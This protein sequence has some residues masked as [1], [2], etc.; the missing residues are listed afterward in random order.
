MLI[1]F[2]TK[3]IVHVFLCWE[4]VADKFDDSKRTFNSNQ[5]LA[6]WQQIAINI[7]IYILSRVNVLLTI[8]SNVGILLAHT[9]KDRNY[10]RTLN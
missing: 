5:K 3:I 6:N 7:L 10:T 8:I 2:Q 9:I 1:S 4:E